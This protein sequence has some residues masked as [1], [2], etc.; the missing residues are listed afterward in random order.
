MDDNEYIEQ[1]IEKRNYYLNIED[2]KKAEEMDE[3][4]NSYKNN[5]TT[6]RINLLK[7]TRDKKIEI[8]N[9]QY[10]RQLSLIEDKYFQLEEKLLKQLSIKESSIMKKHQKELNNFKEKTEKIEINDYTKKIQYNQLKKMKEMLIQQHR[11]PEAEKIKNEMNMLK[12]SQNMNKIEKRKIEVKIQKE[13]LRKKQSKEIERFQ[14]ESDQQIQLLKQLKDKEI[15]KLK[16]KYLNN[17][18]KLNIEYK[19]QETFTKKN[20]AIQSLNN[21]FIATENLKTAKKIPKYQVFSRTMPNKRKSYSQ[22]KVQKVLV[23][24]K[25]FLYSEFFN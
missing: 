11:Y 6:R 21:S 5:I 13:N 7:T 22:E 17:K 19:L 15:E 12:K 10:Q 23:T 2:F 1:M 18:L 24:Q 8:K 14:Y 4:I 20:S 9:T 3:M 25:S 16:Q